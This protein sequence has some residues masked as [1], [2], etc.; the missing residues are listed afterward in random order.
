MEGF[1]HVD[2]S[3]F[4]FVGFL[5]YFAFHDLS[6]LDCHVPLFPELLWFLLFLGFFLRHVWILIKG[7]G[8]E[9]RPPPEPHSQ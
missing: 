1:R 6:S 5:A 7:R 9:Y 2:F 8:A 4:E 3:A